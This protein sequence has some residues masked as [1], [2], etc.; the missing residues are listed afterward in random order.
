M[1]GPSIR[2][3]QE[4]LNVLGANPRLVEDGVFGPRTAAAVRAFQ[5]QRGLNP[6]GIV[7]TVTWNAIFANLS[8]A[9]AT[10]D[11]VESVQAMII[12]DPPLTHVNKQPEFEILAPSKSYR[13]SRNRTLICCLILMLLLNEKNQDIY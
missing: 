11:M 4:R 6:D 13:Q 12:T 7:D 9:L 3:V 5:Q 8:R 1:N 10:T 2:Q